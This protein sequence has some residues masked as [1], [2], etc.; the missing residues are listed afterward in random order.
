MKYITK[1]NKD[2]WSSSII[3]LLKVANKKEQRVCGN[4]QQSS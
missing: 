2:Y 1:I 3:L 4:F